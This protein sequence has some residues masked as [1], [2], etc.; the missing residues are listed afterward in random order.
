LL[1][2]SACTLPHQ[3]I[4]NKVASL[5]SPSSS[6]SPSP[7]PTTAFAAAGP[8]FHAGEVGIAYPAVA[9]TAGGGVKPYR[10]SVSS[11]ALPP[12]LTLGADG[13]VSGTPASAGH[14]NFIIEVADSGDSTATVPGAINI[15]QRLTASLLPACATYC[16]V[17][18]GCANACGAFGT[19][20]GGIAPYTFS[21]KQGRVP[22]GTKLSPSSLTLNGTFGGNPGYLQFTVQVGDAFGATTMI[23]PKFWMYAHISVAG[24][25]TSCMRIFTDC[26]LRLPISGG[27]P[28]GNPSVSLVRYTQQ[29]QGCWYSD[30]TP[31]PGYLLTVSGGYVVIDVPRPSGG[32]GAIWTVVVTDHTYCAANTYCTSP[33]ATVNI[34]I[35][36]T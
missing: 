3:T 12:G 18:I 24:D 19:F 36:C 22:V 30:P 2:I 25:L 14:F 17:E 34:G 8:G 5:A 28:G 10:W 26:S 21:V 4:D 6:P 23:A 16:R 29:V 20:T 35:E 15:A 27:V 1:V 13:T 11:G 32:Y 31:P 33:G 9:L 7:T